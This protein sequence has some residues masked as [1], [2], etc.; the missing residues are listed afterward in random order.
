MGGFNSKKR[1]TE[2]FFAEL[3]IFQEHYIKEA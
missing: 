1:K 2:K 3:H